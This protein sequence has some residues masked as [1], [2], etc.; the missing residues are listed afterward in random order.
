MQRAEASEAR[1][2][3]LDA[4]VE[5][6]IARTELAKNL[7]LSVGAEWS[8]PAQLQLP[9]LEQQDQMALLE[10]ARKS[11]LDLAAARARTDVLAD[12]LGV[13]N[14]TRWLG[15]L[16]VG[17]ERERETDGARL[18]GPT[19]SWEIPV[20]NTQ[21]DQVLRANADLQMAIAEVRRLTIAVDNEVRLAFAAM[22]NAQT[23]VTEIR[24]V[25][26]P[27]RMETVEQAQL[28]VN[29]MFIGVF[30]LI[31]L[32][33]DEYD[34]YQN[35]LESIRDYWVSRTQLGLAVGNELPTTGAAYSSLIDVEEFIRP[36]EPAMD[37]SMH[38]TMDHSQH[39]SMNKEMG[40]PMDHSQHGAMED[41]DNGE[42][43]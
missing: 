27:Q 22:Q 24:E 8:V 43:Q 35:Y 20:F 12:S 23:R 29:Y 26:I 28:E 2:T 7:G 19:L 39:E 1:L 6:F 38:D 16:E 41:T 15:D 4:D 13:I 34:T 40:E 10:L 37:H 30:E 42:R 9:P 31:T 3:A 21:Q 36:Q 33:R 11:R 32:K 5:A 18:T 17:I 25:L 14:W